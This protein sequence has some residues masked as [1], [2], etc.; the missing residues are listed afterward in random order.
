MIDLLENRSS[1]PGQPTDRVQERFAA[2][3]VPFAHAL[4]VF[5]AE[6]ENARDRM[7]ARSGAGGWSRGLLRE[8]DISA[9][10][11]A[12]VEQQDAADARGE[13]DKLSLS[14]IQPERLVAA[15]IRQVL[16]QRGMT[17]SELAERVGVNPSV[18][19]RVLSHPEKAKV[20]TLRS[21][22]EALGIALYSVI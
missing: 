11:L 19:S 20:E 1:Q 2:I 12:L 15:R 22:A 10:D 9:E 4:A 8:P 17:Q 7:A 3:A 16:K 14:D 6:Y 13:L 5:F 18:I 21:Y